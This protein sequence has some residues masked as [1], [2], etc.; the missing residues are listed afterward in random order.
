MDWEREIV[1]LQ[2][3]PLAGDVGRA[4]AGAVFPAHRRDLLLVAEENEAPRTLVTLLAGL[5]DRPFTS[6][7]EVTVA[8]ERHALPHPGESA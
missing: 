1:N 3:H 2:G 7:A 5:P 8:V 4:L 6:A